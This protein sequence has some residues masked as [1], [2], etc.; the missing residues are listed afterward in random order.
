MA[1]AE[2]PGRWAVDV[3]GAGHGTRYRYRLDGG[4][5]LADPASRWQPDGVHG[6]SAVVD[7][8]RFA[9]TDGDWRGIALADAVYYELHVGVFTPEGTLDAA[10]GQ[11]DRLAALG[12]TLVELMPLSATPGAR[13]WGYDGVFPSAVEATYGGPDELARFVD[14]AHARGLGVVLD[15]VYNHLGPEGNVLPRYGP[16]FV[17]TTRTPWGDALNVAGAG[18]DEV[19]DLFVQSAGQWIEDFHVDGLRLDAVDAIVDQTARPFLEELGQAVHAR[20]ATLGREVL[21]VAESASNDPRLVTPIEA[22]GVGLDGMWNDDVHHCLH[23]ALL[24][25]RRGYYADYDGVGD[26]AHALAH[27]WVFDGRYSAFRGRRH[28]RPAD[29]VDPRRLVV[30]AANHDHVGNTPDGRRP[31][32]GRAGRLVAAATVVLG[33]F[34]PLLFMGEEYAETAPFPFFVDHTDLDLLAATRAGRQAEFSGAG[35]DRPVADPADEATFRTA[36][37]DPSQGRARAAPVGA[38]G[39]D[40]AAP[41]AAGVAGPDRPVRRP[42]REARRRRRRRDPRA[43][44]RHHPADP[45]VRDNARRRRPRRRR[46]V[47]RLRRRRSPVGRGRRHGARGRSPAQRRPERAPPRSRPVIWSGL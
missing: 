9:W 1:P 16:Y 38:G 30:F 3:E 33:P 11:L 26:L 31:P 37:L 43:R 35:W 2:R 32:Y 7:P 5:A 24:G 29:H 40:R 13:N 12:V 36:V 28:G 4:D 41:A 20:A 27:R 46:L 44:R 23:V 22:G 6:P 10:I 39:D 8:T 25:D 19:R 14:A 42:R 15:V 17:D 45:R 21:V 18:S 34:T 47:G